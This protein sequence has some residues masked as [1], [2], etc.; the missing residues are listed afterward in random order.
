MPFKLDSSYNK[1]IGLRA[2]AA[3][4]RYANRKEQPQQQAQMDDELPPLLVGWDEVEET[5]KR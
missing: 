1:P 3:A 5:L 2:V 4:V